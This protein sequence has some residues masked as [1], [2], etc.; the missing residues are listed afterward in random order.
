MRRPVIALVLLCTAIALPAAE[1]VPQPP[2]ADK[3]AAAK[4]PP[5]TVNDLPPAVKAAAEAQA[6]GAII[7]KVRADE[8]GG[9]K[10]Y[11]VRFV[12]D[13]VKTEVR[14]NAEAKIVRMKAERSDD[15]ISV[16]TTS[17][18]A[19]VQTT[20]ATKLGDGKIV[21]IEEKLEKGAMIY[22]I[23]MATATG[24]VELTIDADGKLVGE[25]AKTPDEA[26]PKKEKQDKAAEAKPEQ[27]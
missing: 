15:K 19:A 25:K 22:R 17:L 13:G 5:L 3:P 24:I 6:A 2:K 7:D 4:T 27:K 26:K 1:E 23:D 20:V 11:S 10:T 12:R 21:K 9:E 18:P 14:F 16:P 8:K